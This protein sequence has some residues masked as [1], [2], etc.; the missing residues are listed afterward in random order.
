MRCRPP[1]IRH[2]VWPDTLRML[3]IRRQASPLAAKI[4]PTHGNTIIFRLLSQL[5]LLG[6]LDD[7]VVVRDENCITCSVGKIYN[8]S[9]E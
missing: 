6:L 1:E 8:H 5:R 9:C 4:G 3:I 7:L 2:A